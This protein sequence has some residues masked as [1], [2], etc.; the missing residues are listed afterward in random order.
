MPFHRNEPDGRAR[1][2]GDGRRFRISRLQERIAPQG[3]RHGLEIVDHPYQSG[4]RCSG[5]CTIR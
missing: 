4:I 3:D 1:H 5:A 2:E